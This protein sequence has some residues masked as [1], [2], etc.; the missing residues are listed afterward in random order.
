MITKS[1][2]KTLYNW[3]K[4]VKFPVKK[5]P[6]TDGYSNK[7]IDY[8]WIKSVK[9]TTIL[10]DKLMSDNVREIYDNDDILFSNYT[11]FHAGT[12]LKPHKDPDILREPYKRIQIPLRVPDKN[13]CYM[14]WIDRCVKNESQLKWEEGKPQV[15]KV[16]HYTHEAFNLSNKPLEILFVDVKL[17]TEVEI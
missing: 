10:R 5:A 4:N 13:L 12:I 9:K 6:T 3:A 15:C 8:Y 11:I 14:Q 2:L 16:M 7:V 1:D 17:N